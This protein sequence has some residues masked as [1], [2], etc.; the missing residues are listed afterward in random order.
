MLK[1]S[2]VQC[3]V[4]KYSLSTVK[5]SHIQCTVLKYSSI[6]IILYIYIY[7]FD[8][9]IVHIHIHI[10][11]IHTYSFNDTQCSYEYTRGVSP[12]GYRVLLSDN[13]NKESKI[14][15]QKL[16]V[17]PK[18]YVRYNWIRERSPP[19]WSSFYEWGI[20]LLRWV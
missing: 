15:I 9:Y 3:T 19:E 4:L 12:W 11:Y 17:D 7:I 14:T 1:Y 6:I 8:N 13:T 16:H 5:Y 20:I 10:Q 18:I 2:H